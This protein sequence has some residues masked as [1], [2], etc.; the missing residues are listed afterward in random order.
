MLVEG[1]SH[2]AQRLPT[3]TEPWSHPDPS[4]REV[5]P[6]PGERPKQRKS[7]SLQAPVSRKSQ[8]LWVQPQRHLPVPITRPVPPTT[9]CPVG[10]AGGPAIWPTFSAHWPRAAKTKTRRGP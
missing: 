7:P 10:Q 4:L 1:A 3:K 2:P 6:S 8:L 9:Q 5:A